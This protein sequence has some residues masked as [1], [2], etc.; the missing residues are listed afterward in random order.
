MTDKDNDIVEFSKAKQRVIQQR[1]TAN[2]KALEKQFK[3]A[4]G[5]KKSRPKKKPAGNKGPSPRG[6]R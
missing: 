4:M 2:E 3:K 6:R 5:W 1:K